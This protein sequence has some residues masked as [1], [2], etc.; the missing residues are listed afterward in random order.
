MLEEKLKILPPWMFTFLIMDFVIVMIIIL[1]VSKNGDS[2]DTVKLLLIVGSI[3]TVLILILNFIH[4][5]VK[6]E[7]RHFSVKMVPF[8][9][10]PRMIT[11]E[12]IVS[13]K[14][15]PFRAMREFSGYGKRKRGNVT[16]YIVDS[17]FAIEFEMKEGNRIVVS[18]RDEQK[19]QSILERSSV[20]AEKV[21][22]D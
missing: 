6:M 11:P 13:W 16:A 1:A 14:I 8:A 19:W 2:R 15:R 22:I 20:W 5:K 18:I 17:K 7:Y 4:F 21:K 12:E 9:V 10:K 3:F